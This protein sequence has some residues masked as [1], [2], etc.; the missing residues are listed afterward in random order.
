[1]PDR[2]GET[3]MTARSIVRVQL[4]GLS[5]A[6]PERYDSAL[7]LLHDITPLVRALPPDAADIDITGAR[8]V[9][10]ANSNKEVVQIVRLRLAAH[11]GLQATLGMAGSRMLAAMAADATAPGGLTV[12]PTDPDGIT[13]WLRP[14]PVAHLPGIGPATARTLSTYGLHTIGALADTPLLTLQRLLGTALGRQLHTRA[15]GHDPRPVTP[16]TPTQSTSTIHFDRDELDPAAHRRAV[17]ALAEEIGLRLRTT[18]QITTTLTLSIRYADGSTTTRQRILPEATAHTPA[19]AAAGYSLY[20]GCALQRARVRALSL[21]ADLRPAE[22]AVRQLTLDPSD[23]KAR[24]VE[25]AADR[26][27]ARFGPTAVRSAAVLAQ[28]PHRP[29]TRPDVRPAPY[30]WQHTSTPHGKT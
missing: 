1:V 28:P 22:E 13:R 5:P 9:H 17:L 2:Q 15:Q 7:A 10:G 8:R 3:L 16:K 23:D 12:V 4:H 26:V 21:R 24:A 11:L 27:R 6:Q 19:L 30:R 29:R 18:A 25:A 20:D 14:R